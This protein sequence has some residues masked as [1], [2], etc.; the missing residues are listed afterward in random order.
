MIIACALANIIVTVPITPGGLGVME[1]TLVAPLVGFGIPPGVALLGV[2][3]WW[4]VNFWLPVPLGV[5][6]LGPTTKVRRLERLVES[7]VNH[8]GRRRRLLS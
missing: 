2:V 5:A 7:A 8:C 6:Q 3:S 4:L 1:V